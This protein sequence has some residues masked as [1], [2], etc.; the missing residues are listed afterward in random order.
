MAMVYVT[1]DLAVV[2]SSRIASPS[3]TRAASSSRDRPPRCFAVRATRTRAGSSP[4][5]PITSAPGLHRRC[6]AS[7]SASASARSAAPFAPRCVRRRRDVAR[8][9]R[10]LE[11][12]AR[13]SVA[14]LRAAR[15]PRPIAP[16]RRSRPAPRRRRCYG[17]RPSRGHRGRRATVIAAGDMTFAIGRGRMRRARRRVRQRQDDDRPD[18]AGL[19]PTAGGHDHARRRAA[20]A[21][22][23]RRRASHRRRCRSSS[24]TRATRSTPASAIEQIAGRPGPARA[25]PARGRG[26]ASGCSSSC[27]C[28][29]GRERTPPSCRAASAS[30]SGSPAPSRPSPT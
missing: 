9:C 14:L 15:R 12:S 7:P 5:S 29:R 27:G 19:H 22:R 4:R 11:D 1:H 13:A 18:V 26:R 21:T 25:R 28:R 6:R 17:S 20:R 30:A 24:R 8:G 2:A 23:R 10:E 16:E 3:C